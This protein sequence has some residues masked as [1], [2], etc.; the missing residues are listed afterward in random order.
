M[1]LESQ[2]E[3]NLIAQLTRMPGRRKNYMDQIYRSKA[4]MHSVATAVIKAAYRKQGLISG[5]KY[6]AILTTLYIDRPLMS[7]QDMIQAFSR[8]NRIFDKD[9]TWGQIV[10]YQYPKTFS[11][12][13]DDAIVLYSNG[14]E[15][16]AVAPS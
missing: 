6:S 10:T 3:D 1:T 4:H 14:G 2:L 13:I 7:P 9:K 11:E 5:K 12:K 15:K 8:T 16:Y